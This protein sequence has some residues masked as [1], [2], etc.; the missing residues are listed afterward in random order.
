M[1]NSQPKKIAT[2]EE[3]EELLGKEF[4][5]LCGSAISL[6]MKNSDQQLIKFLPMV[7]DVSEK[8]YALLGNSL[9]AGSYIEQVLSYYSKNISQGQFRKGRED[10]KFEEFLWLLE[11]SLSEQDVAELLLALYKCEPNQF[12]VNH[13]AIGKLM[14][15][16]RV[17]LCLTTNFDNAIEV[18]NPMIRKL[19]H[20]ETLIMD[21]IPN[22]ATLLKLHG[23]VVEGSYI[24]TTPNLLAAERDNRFLYLERLLENQTMLVVGYSARGD[25]D[26]APHLMNLQNRGTKLIWIV[27]PWLE[28]PSDIATHWF[29][30]DI[31]LQNDK[32]CLINLSKLN[33]GKDN[34]SLVVPPWEDRL[35]I[36]L[37]KH[38]NTSASR[39]II[40]QSVSLVSGWPKLRLY[41]I[42]K[43]DSEPSEP[44][45]EI[46]DLIDFFDRCLGIGVYYSALNRLSRINLESLKQDY[47]DLYENLVFKEA[48]CF[49]RLVR[50]PKARNGFEYFLEQKD[51][52]K[53][54]NNDE[55]IR[56][57]LEV[58]RDIL[59][60]LTSDEAVKKYYEQYN[61][62]QICD[63]L[64]LLTKNTYNPNS[65]LLAK[66]VVL[67]IR[68]QVG[69]AVELS[70]FEL[71]YQRAIDL[72]IWFIARHA[73]RSMMRIN[74]R[75]G[76]ERLQATS[77]RVGFISWHTFKHT[78][79]SAL[80]RMPKFI[81]SP[82][83]LA[84]IVLSRIPVYG[85]EIGFRTRIMFWRLKYR[86]KLC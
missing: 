80:D 34:I 2:Y 66:L 78:I 49:W 7:Y 23:D 52:K 42:D 82:Y 13:I 79:L 11:Q 15:E 65:E 30:S 6:G 68:C 46:T 36:W 19:V 63:R 26:I 74:V 39:Q 54:T 59:A 70:D 75:K 17:K 32:N 31:T 76:L 47:L 5:V 61:I 67:D 22:T 38:I 84:N 72:Q 3:L 8:F 28:P 43:W 4:V 37:N 27:K 53:R 64:L 21:A 44:T 40:E 86:L 71:I 12:L 20:T 33:Q 81:M 56:L 57:Y 50:L 62:K 16:E 45:N 1:P 14:R 55:G 25:T 83:H 24:A 35:S 18:A 77:R 58:T 9:E 10:L 48:F 41:F 60:S 51:S 85:R 69:E 73:A 29:E